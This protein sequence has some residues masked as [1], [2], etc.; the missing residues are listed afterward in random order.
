MIFS[1][2]GKQKLNNF[3]NHPQFMRVFIEFG[4]V[5][6]QV[7]QAVNT[8]FSAGMNDVIIVHDDA[9]VNNFTFFVIK[10]GQIAGL[11]FFDKTLRH[12][13]CGLLRGIS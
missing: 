4:V 5:N 7:I 8:Y 11:T 13:L 3:F 12:T 9:D 1:Y 6:S 10:K 2:L